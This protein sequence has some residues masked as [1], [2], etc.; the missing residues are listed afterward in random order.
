MNKSAIFNFCFFII[1]ISY[2]VYNLLGNKQT[3]KRKAYIE[4]I[5]KDELALQ[6]KLPIS[7]TADAV[8]IAESLLKAEYGVETIEKLK[9]LIIN[10]DNDI[11]MISVLSDNISTIEPILINKED[12]KILNKK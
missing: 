5:K 7:T 2:P 12:G 6:M 11:W 3:D 4:Q 8:S 10:Y 1:I 9:P